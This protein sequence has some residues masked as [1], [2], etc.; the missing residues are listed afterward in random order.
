ME[1]LVQQ[2][3][4][5]RKEIEA[6]AAGTPEAVEEF[7]IKYLGTKGLVKTIIEYRSQPDRIHF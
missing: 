6:A 1:Q 7:R 5:Y 4:N 2:I 3:D